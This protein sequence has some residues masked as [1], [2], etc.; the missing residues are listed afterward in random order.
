MLPAQSYMAGLNDDFSTFRYHCWANTPVLSAPEVWITHNNGKGLVEGVG[1]VMW[2]ISWSNYP[3]VQCFLYLSNRPQPKLTAP[4]SI[5]SKPK[6]FKARPGHHYQWPGGVLWAPRGDL[7]INCFV[8]MH[9]PYWNILNVVRYLWQSLYF[10]Q[11]IRWWWK[12]H[13]CAHVVNAGDQFGMEEGE[14]Y[15]A[16][17]LVH[18]RHDQYNQMNSPFWKESA[19]TIKNH[20]LLCM[21]SS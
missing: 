20:I 16:L 8:E 21:S 17:H 11:V 3:F 4:A 10:G 5:F 9:Q 12:D 6:S 15:Y 14:S 2:L 7:Y 13:L 19:T 1:H 18:Y